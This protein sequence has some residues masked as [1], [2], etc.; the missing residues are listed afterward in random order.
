MDQSR[1]ISGMALWGAGFVLAEF[2]SRHDELAQLAELGELLGESSTL[3]NTWE[4]KRGVEL[5]AGLGLP[6]I[7]ASK[8]GAHAIATDGESTVLH[9]LR[10]NTERNA[11]TCQVQNLL[12][13]EP[14]PLK[15]LGLSQEPDFVLAADLVY[16]SDPGVWEALAKTIK[17]LSGRSTLVVI[18]NVCRLKCNS[19][20]FFKLLQDEFKMKALSQSLL[21]PD[22]RGD[23][24]GSCLIHLLRRK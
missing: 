7:V 16:G 10:M 21:H 15:A 2:L 18:A 20:P 1:I 17:A 4:G 3:W 23:R 8:L 6:S 19:G 22:F 24:D 12:W 13:G 14:E 9:L 5:G 11:P